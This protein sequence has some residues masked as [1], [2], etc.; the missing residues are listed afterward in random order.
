MGFCCKW[1]RNRFGWK[2]KN[3]LCTY[4]NSF[5]ENFSNCTGCV[6]ELHSIK[7]KSIFYRQSN[8]SNRI[9]L[10]TNFV[11]RTVHWYLKKRRF[12]YQE[13]KR[14]VEN[15]KWWLRSKCIHRKQY[16]CLKFIPW[17]FIVCLIFFSFRD[18]RVLL[19][20]DFFLWIQSF[21]RI[22]F[23]FMFMNLFF[24]RKKENE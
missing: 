12:I 15:D 6:L 18:G 9:H 24:S 20:A 11:Q 21:F 14:K 4:V 23:G 17:L 8:Y 5:V 13:G 16:N 2:K 22:N 19:S 3:K 7:W 1:V 10:C